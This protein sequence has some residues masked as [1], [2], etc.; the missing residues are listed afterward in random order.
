[1]TEQL[2]AMDYQRTLL[3]RAEPDA[4]F[5]ALTTI[6]GL[7]AW[8]TDVTGSGET[9]GELR[10]RFDPPQPCVMRVD[11]ATRPNSV[12]WTVTECGFL[13]D[14]EGTRPTFTIVPADGGSE[15]RFR[16]HGLTRELDCIDDCTS[17]WN[18][19]TESLRQYVETGR[20]MRRGS[21]EDDARRA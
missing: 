11:E 12:R 3:V 1:M 7:S 10:F 18:H 15:L 16:H 19:F 8:W 13:P 14:W 2:S 6:P 5:D 20:G 21:P 17:G 4:L 9:G